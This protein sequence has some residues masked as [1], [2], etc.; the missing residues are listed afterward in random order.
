MSILQETGGGGFSIYD[1]S[2]VFFD[3][4]YFQRNLSDSHSGPLVPRASIYTRLHPS[5]QRY[6]QIY[7]ELENLVP[8]SLKVSS[9]L[10]YRNV[11]TYLDKYLTDKYQ[12]NS[13]GNIRNQSTLSADIKTELKE[14]GAIQSEVSNCN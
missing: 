1:N 5:S 4:S 9:K 10:V 6:M 13:P 3:R 2:V 7:E 11:L 14:W 8:D 12:T